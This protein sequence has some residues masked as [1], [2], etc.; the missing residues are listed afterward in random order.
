MSIVLI[1]LMQ[2]YVFRIEYGHETSDAPSWRST[3]LSLS[4]NDELG[5]QLL[6]GHSDDHYTCVA[7]DRHMVYERHIMIDNISHYYD[8]SFL[9]RTSKINENLFPTTYLEPY[10]FN[11][12][13]DEWSS[14]G[15]LQEVALQHPMK[16]K[17][18][19]L[20]WEDVIFH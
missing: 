7:L 19:D 1:N 9:M 3:T 2:N 14:C 6:L 8:R 4:S 13:I 17:D 12:V 16:C 18:S 5:G 10:G 11:L 15:D 20:I